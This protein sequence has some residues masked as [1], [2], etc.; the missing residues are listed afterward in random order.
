MTGFFIKDYLSEDIEFTVGMYADQLCCLRK[1]ASKIAPYLLPMMCFQPSVWIILGIVSLLS[2]LIWI[3]IRRCHGK[4]GG[5]GNKLSR[6]IIFQMTIDSLM[7]I[8]S[9]PMRKLPKPSS[10]RAFI[11]SICL[12]SLIFVSIF[13]SSLSTVFIK[14]I[15]HKDINTLAGLSKTDVKI[16][17]KYPAM[18]D[19]LFPPD[20]V[21][22]LDRLRKKMV[23]I[24]STSSLMDKVVVDD[25]V[26]SVTRKELIPQSYAKYF[27]ARKVHLIQECPRTYNLGYVGQ[28]NSVFMDRVNEVLLRLNNGGF[29]VKWIR[30]LNYNYTWIT[31]KRDGIFHEDSF[32]VL[33]I[34][35]FQL[36]FFILGFGAGISLITL[37][38]EHLVHKRVISTNN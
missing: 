33:T 18:M 7:L 26:V 19:D 20:S 37:L 36:P 24:Q 29:H 2:T 30:D 15:F 31:L 11:S 6:G 1:K 27:S 13:Q 23:L 35:D 9:T 4:F 22:T 38:F 14:P 32:K 8:L 16:Y 3:I 10:E 21:G 12:V 25:K 17:I 34:R 5:S 28:K